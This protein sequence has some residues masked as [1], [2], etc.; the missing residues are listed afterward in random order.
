[1]RSA[2]KDPDVIPFGGGDSLEL[3]TSKTKGYRDIGIVWMSSLESETTV[4][5]FDGNY[6][7]MRTANNFKILTNP[8]T[9]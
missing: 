8:T 6:Y 4:Y 5:N 3:L 2:R 9:P 7:K 1:V